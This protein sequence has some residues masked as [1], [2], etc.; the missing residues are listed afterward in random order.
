MASG[1]PVW[2]LPNTIPHFSIRTSVCGG[3]VKPP[4]LTPSPRGRECC[5]PCSTAC[6]MQATAAAPPQPQRP[7]QGSLV[8]EWRWWALV[9]QLPPLLTHQWLWVLCRPSE[10]LLH[11]SEPLYLLP[12]LL[13]AHWSPHLPL[14]LHPSATAVASQLRQ[15]LLAL[16]PPLDLGQLGQRGL[17]PVP[18]RFPLPCNATCAWQ[19]WAP[20]WTPCCTACTW[21]GSQTPPWRR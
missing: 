8:L 17:G 20:L 6:A 10:P 16:Q 13:V 3:A 14:P 1:S 15:P 5:P 21:M 12:L 7:C 4:H 18:R 2:R 11:L 9:P 19:R